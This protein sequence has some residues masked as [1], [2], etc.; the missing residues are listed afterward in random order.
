[1]LYSEGRAFAGFG[2]TLVLEHSAW[3][4]RLEKEKTKSQR[5]SRG[6]RVQ[7]GAGRSHAGEGELAAQ[8]ESS[9]SWHPRPRAPTDHT[10]FWATGIWS[11]SQHARSCLSAPC[12]G[13]PLPPG[14]NRK[15]RRD[16]KTHTEVWA[17]S[18]PELSTGSH[19]LQPGHEDVGNR[20]GLRGAAPAA[21]PLGCRPTDP[22]GDRA[23][24]RTGFPLLAEDK[25]GCQASADQRAEQGAKELALKSGTQHGL[26][27]G[28]GPR[29]QYTGLHPENSLPT[30]A[31]ES[32]AC[33]V[34]SGPVHTA[35]RTGHSLGDAICNDVLSRRTWME[36]L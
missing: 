19:V 14:R 10:R 26:E 32:P 15:A 35:S 2:R 6:E 21:P 22:L 29:L 13:F 17:T 9:G 34:P 7:G 1:M 24:L 30:P 11:S 27:G 16:R 3:L 36:G 33:P 8:P 31:P 5:Q 4:C 23:P 28:V 25:R 18:S 20:W 12:L